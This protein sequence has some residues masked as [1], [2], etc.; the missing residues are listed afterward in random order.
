VFGIGSVYSLTWVLGDR[1][2]VHGGGHV[3]TSTELDFHVGAQRTDLSY[4]FLYVD[5]P[6][7]LTAGL[8]EWRRYNEV[9]P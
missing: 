7:L 8:A 5:R 2:L 9:S 1:W 3:L 4:A 6:Q